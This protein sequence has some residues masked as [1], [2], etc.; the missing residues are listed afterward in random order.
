LVAGGRTGQ[1]YALVTFTGYLPPDRL[2]P[3]L[4]GVEVA[5]VHTRVPLPDEQTDIERIAV[6]RV[7]VDVVAGM[8]AVAD[9]MDLEAANYRSLSAKLTGDGRE[10]RR[11]RAVYTGQAKTAAAEAAAYR[12]RCSC[13]YAA[14]VQGV[15]AALAEVAGRPEVRAVDPAPEVSQLDQAVFLPPLPEQTGVV[16]SPAS[17]APPPSSRAEPRHDQ[18]FHLYRP[19]GTPTPSATAGTVSPRPSSGSPSHSV[20]PSSPGVSKTPTPSVF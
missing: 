10:E 1:A 18:V 13:V 8:A 16:R 7:P 15:P 20:A 14:V 4:A 11:L 5:Q 19:A 6:T 9:R 17:P 12:S 2:A 3:T